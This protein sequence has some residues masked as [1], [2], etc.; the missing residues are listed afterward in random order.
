[1][2]LVRVIDDTSEILVTL[3]RVRRESSQSYW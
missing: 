2:T 1:M 3:V